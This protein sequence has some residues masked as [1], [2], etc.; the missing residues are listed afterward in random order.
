MSSL[1]NILIRKYISMVGL[2]SIINNSGNTTII[3][4][5]SFNSNLNV[6]GYSIVQ[7]NTTIYSSLYISGNTI[8]NGDT[9]FNSSINISGNTRINGSTSILSNLNINSNCTLFG[10]LYVS[11][12]A[13]IDNAITINNNLSI[14]GS[15]IFN[16]IAIST[17]NPVNQTLNIYGNQINIGNANSII[18]II[19]T[20][21]FIATDDFMSTDKLISLNL[22]ASTGTG[23]DIGNSS[24]IEIL[25]TAG[26]GFI[27]TTTDASRF[28]IR[29]PAGGQT[30][31]IATVDIN[32]NLNIS[33]ITTLNNNVSLSSQLY[34][35]GNTIFNN[36]TSINSNL[37]VLNMLLN[38]SVT[39]G[40]S[41]IVTNNSILNGSITIAGIINVNSTMTILGNTTI[42]GSLTVSGTSILTGALTIGS[43]LYVLGNTIINSA[44]TI[45][46]LLNVTANTNIKS[47]VSINSNL[48]INNTS[49]L[50]NTTILS[51]LNVSNQTNIQGALTFASN[52]SVSG[53]VILT[54]NLTLGS[55]LAN[56]NILSSIVSQLPEY[57]DNNTAANAGVANWGWYRTGGVLKIRLN[58]VPPTIYLSSGSSITI[59]SGLSFTDPGAYALDYFNN[60]NPVYMTSIISGN[61]NLLSSNIL[62]SG[63]SSVITQV[64]AL[65]AG[66]YTTTYQATDTTGNIG[67]NYRM[68]NITYFNNI[69][70]NNWIL[71]VNNA[72]GNLSTSEINAHFKFIT[73]LQS[74][75]NAWSKI[76]RLNTFCG[77]SLNAA[78]CPLIIDGGLSNNGAS[79]NDTTQSGTPNYSRTGGVSSTGAAINTGLKITTITSNGQNLHM[80]VYAFT[81]LNGRPMGIWGPIGAWT[82]HY[83]VTD[84]SFGGGNNASLWGGQVYLNA[85]TNSIGMNIIKRNTNDT[86]YFYRN[87]VK[88]TVTGNVDN[89][90]PINW[91]CSV[92]A[93]NGSADSNAANNIYG[94]LNGVTSARLGG[95]TM[96][97][98]LTDA[99]ALD[100]T[101]AFN[102][103]NLD[104][105]RS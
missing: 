81:Q 5:T 86:T 37:N 9:S 10:N 39:I 46:S 70:L 57:P 71:R 48:L 98:E 66:N 11:S 33:G 53:N 67:Y 82:R 23:F 51:N 34:V 32:N 44:L 20:S 12:N 101:N 60:S 38:N 29:P 96:G 50:Q 13:V 35:S 78:L 105:S 102:Q 15:A 103:L 6:S 8:F 18:N 26:T 80:G 54:N 85:N 76:L 91:P 28:I 40:S 84:D 43:N 89:S 2:D 1:D 77:D 83:C 14:N 19:G 7:N 47:S 55:Q 94:T 4:N 74:N 25:G 17:I 49:I 36:N 45:G 93:A 99:Q 21:N 95:Y 52:L 24:G 75:S 27:Q 72:G 68:L 59:Y 92:L 61:T 69:I 58:S 79:L 41:L 65:S 90:Y 88:T 62:I 30:M 22:N 104:L 63:S 42:M 87:G 56:L 3:G 100:I 73:S 64:T 31:F 16:N 97:Y